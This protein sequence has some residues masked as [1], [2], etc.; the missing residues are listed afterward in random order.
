MF[1][2]E[3]GFQRG[4]VAKTLFIE[5]DKK[6]ILIAQVYIDDIVFSSTSEFLSNKFAKKMA[7]E[8]EMSMVGELSF[9][10]GLQIKQTA[11]GIFVSQPKYARELLKKF[12]MISS[13]HSRTP[14][15]T[16]VK[17]SLDSPVKDFN[18]TLYRSMI[19]S[20]L[21]LT[22]SRPDISFSVGVC[23]RYQSKSKES[24]VSAVKRILK[25]ISGTIDYGIWMSKDTNTVIVGFSDADWIEC[26]DDRKSTSSGCFFVGNN[27]VA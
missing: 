6:N 15:S 13:K 4:R 20:L 9:F 1:L 5:Q 17:L 23:A 22:T 18:E 10:L 7:S 24:H 2:I 26:V 19:S 21:Y 25:Y 3:L 8:F 12:G 14:M 11:F 16:T 27:L